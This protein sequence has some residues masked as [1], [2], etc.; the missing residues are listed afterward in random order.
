MKNTKVWVVTQDLTEMDQQVL[1]Y[2]KFLSEIVTPEKIHFVHVINPES[3]YEKVEKD[4]IEII[5]K[6]ISEGVSKF[7]DDPGLYEIHVEIGLPFEEIIKLA[8]RK[9]AG[10]GVAGRKKKSNGSGVVSDRLS[11]NLPFNF[12]LVPEDFE[13]KL[14][15]VLVATDFSEHASLALKAASDL[16]DQKD[17][18]QIFA[19]NCYHVPMGYSKSGKSFEEFAGIMKGNAEK[20]MNRWCKVKDTGHSFSLQ[21]KESF[22]KLIMNDVIA[23]NIDLLIMGSKGQSRI[24]MALLGSNTTKLI[25]HNDRIPLLIVKKEGEN[26]DLID[27]LKLV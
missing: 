6:L 18:L 14:E 9:S 17:D 11:R 19:H 1:R 8:I 10:L 26:L 24:S 3:A 15:R 27:A 23:N 20:E 7:F 5:Q 22:Q 12:L 13:P 16:R 21:E 4:E 25:D 2:V